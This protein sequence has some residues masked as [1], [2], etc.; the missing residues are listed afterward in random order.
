MAFA[1]GAALAAAGCSRS[2]GTAAPGRALSQAEAEQEVAARIDVR[3][4][5]TNEFVDGPPAGDPIRR[6]PPD[7]LR[8]GMLWLANDEAAPWFVGQA[9]GYFRDAGIDLQ[10]LPGGPTRDNVPLLISGQIDVYEGPVEQA[11]RAGLSPTGADLVMIGAVL[12]ETSLAWMMLDRTIPRGQRSTHVVTVADLKGR[13]IGLQAASADYYVAL[14]CDHFGLA[15]SDLPVV[16]AGSTPDGLIAGAMD[17]YQCYSDNQP[18][19]LEQNGYFNYALLPFKDIGY[20][21][22]GEVSLVRRDYLRSHRD[23][24]HRYVFALRRSL[25]EI[26]DHPDESAQIVARMSSTPLT[27]AEVRWRLARDIPLYEGDAREPLL[28][29]NPRNVLAVVAQLYR[30]HEIE[31]PPARN[32]PP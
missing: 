30:F 6:G 26:I 29:M 5:F 4:L 10:L 2:A 23:L 28:A 8:L 11:V 1:A 32:A 21:S 20:V 27:A 31:L 22:Y 19:L 14:A 16:P 7:R 25:R 9:K 24:I 15:P 12:K 18:R 13:R 17:F 3:R